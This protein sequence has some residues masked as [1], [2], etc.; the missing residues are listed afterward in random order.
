[1]KEHVARRIVLLVAVSFLVPTNPALTDT[2]RERYDAADQSVNGG[3][4]Y[5]YYTN[6]TATL[7]WGESYIMM[8]YISAYL[9]TH[10]TC[11]LDKL[12]DHADCV[13]ANR[14]DARG[15]TDYRGVSGACWRDL[16]YQPNDEPYCYVVHS[17]MITYPMAAFVRIVREDESL[18]DQTT[19]DDS[20]YLEK[21]DDYTTAIYE[22]LAYHEDQWRN[23]DDAGYYIFR[24]DAT[25]LQYHGRDLPL[26]QGNALGRTIL[27]LGISEDDQS[28]LARVERMAR[29]LEDQLFFDPTDEV[30]LWNY[31][32]G[33][34][35]PPGE[36]ISHAAINADFARLCGEA[37]VVFDDYDLDFFANTFSRR[38]Y[39]SSE[40]IY[41]RI[42]GTGSYNTTSYTLQIARWLGLSPYD[43]T[44]YTVVRNYYDALDT[45]TGSGSVVLGFANVL[46][47]DLPEVTEWY[48]TIDGWTDEGEYRIPTSDA[49]GIYFIPEDPLAPAKLALT[50][51]SDSTVEIEQVRDGD[52]EVV[53]R[54]GPS[55]KSDEDE[56]EPR[57][58]FFAY[59]PELFGTNDGYQALFLIHGA[60]KVYEGSAEPQEPL[61]TSEPPRT[62]VQFE[63]YVY[64]VEA[65]GTL[66]IH[67]SATIDSEPAQMDRL[68]GLLTHTFDATGEFTVS[69]TAV[70]TADFDNQTFTVA[71]EPPSDDDADD[72]GETDDDDG[73]DDD[74]EGGGC[75]CW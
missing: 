49:A 14:D 37:G 51:E 31:W 32:G 52:G 2:L 69:I 72:D 10:D 29:W 36:D 22:T 33:T 17:G 48:F 58:L 42:G 54:F 38:I 39:E 15:V 68:T 21:A 34:Y 71:V 4:G 28:L 67:F 45:S 24:P 62:A 63:P 73:A 9:G 50:Y 5:K 6:E 12:C 43:A 57:T 1:M 19:Y 44:V 59:H 56:K 70:N 60:D 35:S 41:D 65:E 55:E 8:S 18:W 47:Y 40:R 13:L 7:A 25:F 64:Q 3:D 66:P 23:N 26:N 11:Y 75:G 61:I 16:H 30:Y 46:R 20:T 74:S 53:A 27:A